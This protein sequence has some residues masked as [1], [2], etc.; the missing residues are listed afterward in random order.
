MPTTGSITSGQIV[1]VTQLSEDAI[2][3]AVR[4]VLDGLTFTDTET[5]QQNVVERGDEYIAVIERKVAPIIE[6]TLRELT[7]SD[8]FQS[9]EVPSSYA[10]LSGY[11]GPKSIADQLR[12]LRQYFL[13]FGDADEEIA[14]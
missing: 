1:K 3:R 14:K 7:I 4:T 12:I 13:Q 5:F 6:A 2:R 10:Y 9:E 8:E 11:R